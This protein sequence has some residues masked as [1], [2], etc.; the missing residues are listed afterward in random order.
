MSEYRIKSVR[1]K[2]SV[3]LFTISEHIDDFT[4]LYTED[5][6]IM[7]D[8]EEQYDEITYGRPVMTCRGRGNPKAL[9]DVNNIILPSV[10]YATSVSIWMI[11]ITLNIIPF[12]NGMIYHQICGLSM[13]YNNFVYSYSLLEIWSPKRWQR[14]STN[15]EGESHSVPVRERIATWLKLLL[16]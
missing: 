5:Q 12:F 13:M 6:Y 11:S 2:G 8:M 10:A 16:K 7:Y 14:S 3:A 15:I 4:P 1:N 9:L